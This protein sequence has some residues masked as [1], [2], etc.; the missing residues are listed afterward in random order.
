MLRLRQEEPPPLEQEPHMLSPRTPVAAQS[1]A[2]KAP[3]AQQ[4]GPAVV[5]PT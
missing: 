5:P 1:E 4:M 3:S 2:L